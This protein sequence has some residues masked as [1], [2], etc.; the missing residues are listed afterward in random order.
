[1]GIGR[2]KP[3]I[4]VWDDDYLEQPDQQSR[5]E[6]TKHVFPYD[7]GLHKWDKYQ[8]I[9]LKEPTFNNPD[10]I[11]TQRYVV[12]EYSNDNHLRRIIPVPK[13]WK[14]SSRY[15]QDP[16]IS[17]VEIDFDDVLRLVENLEDEKAIIEFYETYGSLGM[18]LHNVQTIS[19]TDRLTTIP[20]GWKVDDIPLPRNIP[21]IESEVTHREIYDNLLRPQREIYWREGRHWVRR[22]QNFD[23]N[24]YFKGS[25]GWL[26]LQ[27]VKLP[28]L[29]KT[30][31]VIM[32]DDPF[33]PMMM[34]YPID[35]LRMYF[36]NIELHTVD[37]LAKEWGDHLI[38]V[39]TTLAFWTLY[40]EN[41]E[42]FK[43]YIRIFKELAECFLENQDEETKGKRVN[44]RA[45]LN[46]INDTAPMLFEGDR[47]YPDGS[48]RS[49]QRLGFVSLFGLIANLAQEAI[50]KSYGFR[51]CARTSRRR[52][53]D[54][55]A[56]F[57]AK[58]D[59]EYC[60][61]QCTQAMATAR[62]RR[63]QTVATQLEVYEKGMT[64]DEFTDIYK[65]MKSKGTIPV[66]DPFDVYDNLVTDPQETTAGQ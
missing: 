22:T 37:P 63:W 65:D 46:A 26:H 40:G 48:T 9:E 5:T 2:Y 36:P 17:I 54:C 1:M 57:L 62:K 45:T 32:C 49:E 64:V 55:N 59:K 13:G 61:Q 60:S 35:Y 52:D 21:Q 19:N 58:E 14:A 34:E 51:V 4:S 11:R 27:P 38:P 29:P 16:N 6:P 39:P 25:D 28:S 33:N 23:T 10:T 7:G 47:K 43:M 20:T 53:N 66:P 12:P 31:F 42:M 18:L 41:R 56:I 8:I 15:E 44:A 24:P 30:G 50:S 3:G